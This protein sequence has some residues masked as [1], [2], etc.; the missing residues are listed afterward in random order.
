MVAYL[1]DVRWILTGNM[2]IVK[3]GEREK[4]HAGSL[5]GKQ[6]CPALQN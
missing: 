4:Y 3:L 2:L 5:I 1:R 6:G